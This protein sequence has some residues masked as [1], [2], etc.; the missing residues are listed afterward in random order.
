MSGLPVDRLLPG[1]PH[2]RGA[3][4]DGLGANFAVFSAHASRVDLCVFDPAGRREIARLPLPECTDEVFHGY[5]PEAR[6]GLLYGYRAY[7]PYRPEQGHRFN[8]HKLLIDPYARG[9]ARDLSWTDALFGYSLGSRR[10]DLS[11]DRRDSAAA[12]PRSVLC[13]DSFNWGN[14][15]NPRRP[16]SDTVIYEMHVRG[17]TM[18]CEALPERHR[19][20]FAG[21]TNPFVIDH[22]VNL[23]VTAVEF[24][25]VHAFLQDRFL[26]EK[27]LRNYWGYS[28]L[29]FFAPERRYLYDASAD[30]LR[31][32]VRRLHAAGIEVILDVV[33]NHTCEGSE[34]GPT[35][36]WRG[37]DNASYYRSVAGQPRHLVNDTGTGNTLNTSHPRVLQMVLDS[38]RHWA[39][40]YRIDGFRFDLCSTLGREPHGFNPDSPLFQAIL[41]DPVLRGVKL[42]AEP[43]DIGPGGYQLGQHPPGFAEWND[44]FRDGT[45]RF[46]RGD[47]GQR[48][49]LAAR[50]SGSGDLFDRRRRRSWASINFITAHDGFTLDDLTSYVD[51]H[52]EANLE[53]NHDGHSENLSTNWGVEGP[54][55]DPAIL[56]LRDRV[57]RSLLATLMLSGGTPMLLAGDEVRK[58]QNGNNNAYCHDNELS[59]MDWTRATEPASRAL[60]E[61]VARLI[62]LRRSSRSIHTD[63]FQ[64]GRET[65]APGIAD[66]EWFDE[67]GRVLTEDAWNDGHAQLLSLRRAAAMERGVSVTMLMINGTSDDRVFVLPSPALAWTIRI[68]TADLEREDTAVRG[69]TVAVGGHGVVLLVAT[70][71]PA[72]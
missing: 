62:A 14:D 31:V 20:T 65:P 2:P 27:G 71:E 3:T 57:R 43:W 61:Y 15:Q 42:I 6:P 4:W 51:K 16:W 35:L 38:L 7:G 60:Y 13:D 53:N 19:G 50:L 39:T 11:F 47:T 30:D 52:N 5:L 17:F 68:D 34:L 29:A 9:L 48:A 21:L 37:L 10:R 55:N 22:L 12:M 67:S 40:S 44:R 64:H 18:R 28:T 69:A 33:Y 32:A 66:I 54:T 72:P 1:S 23:G 45:R 56:A 63:R 26:V 8:H 58:T 70:A 46:W 36:S 25:P 24:L 49:E 59:W 41:Q